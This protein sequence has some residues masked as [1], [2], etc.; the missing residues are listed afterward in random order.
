MNILVSGAS[1]LIGSTLVPYL[2]DKGH[3]IVR[4]TRNEQDDVYWNPEKGI[5][6][7]PENKRFEAV[8]H[9]AGENIA[10]GRWNARKMK[11]IRS[12]RIEGTNILVGTITSLDPK[13]KVMLSASGIGIYGNQGKR[14]L[15]EA[16]PE[17]EGFLIDVSRE[18]EAA[19]RPAQEAGI[20]V[21]HM[22]IAP[23]LSKHGG[24][25]KRMLPVFKLGLGT[26]LGSGKQY[27]S[28]ITI[29]DTVRAIDH[30]LGNDS[31]IGPVNLC[32]PNP[33]TNHDFTKILGQVLHRPA[34]FNMPQLVL[35]IMFGEIADQ[36]LVSSTRAVPEKLT[37]TGFK[38][39]Y[40]ELEE[41]LRHLLAESH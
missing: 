3:S 20:R 14:I 38:F 5:I 18:W 25:L 12:S 26:S 27:M 2:Q 21:A 10:E 36:E 24:M 22:R 41:G 6:Q 19:T 11:R 30:L 40:P 1:G 39:N 31:L 35:K 29:D 7:L 37:N 17:G 8:I 33:V 34:I 23:V 4:L 9:L 16:D 28:W 32:S 15:T 13:P